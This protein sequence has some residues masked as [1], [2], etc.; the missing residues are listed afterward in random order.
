MPVSKKTFS[1]Q[2]NVTPTLTL[3]DGQY[4]DHLS[5]TACAILDLRW[6]VGIIKIPIWV[7]AQVH[8][9]LGKTTLA[10][11]SFESKCSRH[12][13]AVQKSATRPDLAVVRPSLLNPVDFRV[14]F[15]KLFDQEEWSRESLA[16]QNPCLQACKDARADEHE[17]VAVFVALLDELHL[18]WSQGVPHFGGTH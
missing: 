13:K 10:A 15:A 7:R 12:V 6:H 17:C 8:T 3:E 4:F 9:E 11:P 18:P 2:Q 5:S 14:V 16:F 1:L